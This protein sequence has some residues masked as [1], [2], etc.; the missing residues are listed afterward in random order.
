[1]GAEVKA[2]E[3][4]SDGAQ[5]GAGGSV[6]TGVSAA[7]GTSCRLERTVNVDRFCFKV[8]HTPRRRRARK[9][10]SSSYHSS[11]RLYPRVLSD[12]R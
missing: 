1:M 3:V 5:A 10:N 6:S 12:T 9:L 7:I 4:G 8:G 11:H 2:A